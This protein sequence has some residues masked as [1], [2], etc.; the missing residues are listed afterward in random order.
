MK[1]KISIFARKTFALVIAMSMSFPTGVIAAGE[2]TKT[3]DQATSIMGLNEKP[4]EERHQAQQTDNK[5]KLETDAYIMQARA[6]LD[7][8]LEKISYQVNISNKNK[9]TSDKDLS[10]K[11]SPNPNSNITDIRVKSA[12]AKIENKLAD[13][14]IKERSNKG[15][16]LSL[17]HI[18]E[19]TR[20]EW[21]SRMPSSA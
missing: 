8:E 4:N 16:I 13:I 7:Q 19:P 5:D 1:G 18:S 3:Y 10:L 20:R 14:D 9:D 17:I 15:E 21:L 12:K 6:S 11:F 2:E